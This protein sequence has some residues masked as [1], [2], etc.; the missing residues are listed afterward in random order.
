M[1]TLTYPRWQHALI[2]GKYE[3]RIIQSPD[4]EEPEVWK[5]SPAHLPWSDN[6]NWVPEK[7]VESAELSP[8]AAPA[9]AAPA[10]KKGKGKTKTPKPE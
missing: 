4:Q 6:P 1:S 8:E 7:P 3:S 5:E 9:E 2:D 10:P